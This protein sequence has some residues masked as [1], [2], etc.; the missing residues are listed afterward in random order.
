MRE[1]VAAA[2]VSTRDPGTQVIFS[3]AIHSEQPD[4]RLLS[5]LGL[6]A[7]RDPQFEDLL[8]N[9]LEDPIEWVRI[10][11][12]LALGSLQT[13]S[14]L[15]KIA[16]VLTY[17]QS[18]KQRQAIAETFAALPEEGYP[19]LYDA[20]QDEDIMLR[21][22]AVFGLSRVPTNWALI[23]IYRVFLEDQQWYVRSGAQQVFQDLRDD[24]LAAWGYPQVESI[25]WLIQWATE[26]DDEQARE[27]SGAELLAAAQRGSDPLIRELATAT[28][29]QLGLIDYIKLLYE[30]LNDRETSVREIAYRALGDIQMRM[31]Q[32]LPAP[33]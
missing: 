9:Y 1:R 32:G 29:G 27:A 22:A 23:Q 26:L 2:L 8:A 25:P 12:S 17:S 16:E 5:C 24:K 4:L 28:I 10:A 11:A 33:Q 20:V 13:E 21:R 19:L 30:A 31:G 18:E 7:F 15:T 14:S 6:G 3:K